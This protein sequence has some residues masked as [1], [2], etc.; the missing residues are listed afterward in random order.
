MKQNAEGNRHITPNEEDVSRFPPFRHMERGKLREVLALANLRHATEGEHLFQNGEAA[1]EFFLLVDGY[2]R[3]SRTTEHGEQL[4]LHHVTPG[5]LFGITKVT[6][7]Q[8]YSVSAKA[9]TACVVLTW[10]AEH[11]DR[12]IE[13]NPSFAQDAKRTLGGRMRELADKVVGLATRSVEQRI[14][15]TLLQLTERAGTETDAGTEIAF[16]ITRQDI[17]DTTG[18]NMHSVSRIMSAW[19]RQKIVAGSRRK[20]V[21]L[22]P[23]V[24]SQLLLDAPKA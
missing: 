2:A 18:A 4:V 19:Q 5:T 17:A 10:R 16:P 13:C 23:K 6:E 22:Q 12:I 14:A 21:V 15:L 3:L 1:E 24:L 9:A 20:I 7:S 11:W 8:T